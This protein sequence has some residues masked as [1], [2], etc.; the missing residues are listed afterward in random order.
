MANRRDSYGQDVDLAGQRAGDLLRAWIAGDAARFEHELESILTGATGACDSGEEERRNL[1]RAVALRMKKCPDVFGLPRKAAVELCLNL[2]GHLVMEEACGAPST[3][4]RTE[5]L[6]AE[7]RQPCLRL[8][9]AA[10][11]TKPRLRL[12]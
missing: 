5:R 2:L 11:G 4:P 7:D 9:Y 8:T 6:L 1:L 12:V 3:W 10:S